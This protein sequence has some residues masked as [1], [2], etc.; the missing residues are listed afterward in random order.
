MSEKP[1]APLIN[2]APVLFIPHINVITD[3][4]R[5]LFVEV[6]FSEQGSNV[7]EKEENS[8]M[9]FLDYLA[10]CEKGSISKL[11]IIC[12]ILITFNLLHS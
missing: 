12:P 3:T 5:K 11:P 6:R 2:H 1:L 10:E 8:Y 9:M 4:F 7:R